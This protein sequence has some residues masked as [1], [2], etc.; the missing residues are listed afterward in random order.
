MLTLRIEQYFAPLPSVESRFN[1]MR[2]MI[3]YWFF[4]T[5]SNWI[6][7]IIFKWLWT[8]LWIDFLSSTLPKFAKAIIASVVICTLAMYRKSYGVPTTTILLLIMLAQLP[9]AQAMRKIQKNHRTQEKKKTPNNIA[10]GRRAQKKALDASH[11]F[12]TFVLLH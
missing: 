5:N 3:K 4:Y 11:P 8:I 1:E 2:K 12:R 9:I 10:K 7:V 6:C